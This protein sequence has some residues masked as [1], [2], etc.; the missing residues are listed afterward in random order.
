MIKVSIVVPVYNREDYLEK[1]IDSLLEQ[2]YKEIEIILF[3]NASTD[4]SQK[5]IDKYLALFPGEIRA[6]STDLNL[7][8]GGGRN[9]GLEHT[10]GDYVCFI[11][12]DDYIDDD[13]IEQLVNTANEQGNMPDM[14]ISN[15]KKVNAKGDVIYTRRY[16]NANQA[17]YQSIAPW[18]KMFRKEYLKEKEI[19]MRNIPFAEDV[20]F[21]AELIVS[22]AT[23]ALSPSVG[24]CWLSNPTSTS[25]TAFRGFPEGA[26]NKAFDYLDYMSEK[27]SDNVLLSYFAFKYC[28]WYLLH[29]GRN[30]G[31]KRMLE[32]YQLAFDYLDEKFPEYIDNQSISIFKPKQERGVVRIA[33][34]SVRTMIKI[35]IAKHFFSVYS[36]L[37]VDMLWPRL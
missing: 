8:A 20:L 3:N 15:F 19:K 11:D 18:G 32:Q 2:T 10:N 13:Y 29:S 9:R 37:K 31:S 30:S 5:I 28:V 1:C 26:L 36:H 12:S 34:W 25:N 21:I 7:G 16:L 17:V 27:Y 14:V 4:N 23:V 35:G 22:K 33:M 6:Y 24:Y